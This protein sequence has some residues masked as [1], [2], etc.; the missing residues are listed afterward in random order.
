MVGAT[1]LAY[2][3]LAAVCQK[4]VKWRKVVIFLKEGRKEQELVKHLPVFPFCGGF[5]L[6]LHES[7]HSVWGSEIFCFIL[8]TCH[9]SLILFKDK[10]R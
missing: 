5:S 9:C 2:A 8:K 7:F 3:W 4:D 6:W 1:C 10:S